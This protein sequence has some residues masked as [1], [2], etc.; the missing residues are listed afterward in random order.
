[1]DV[2]QELIKQIETD[3]A[4]KGHRTVA[5]VG[6]RL[7]GKTRKGKDTWLHAV[8]A[9][10][11]DG[12]IDT[13]EQQ[14]GLAIPESLRRLYRITNGLNLFSDE[15]SIDGLRRSFARTADNA[16]QPYSLVEP[17]TL[18]RPSGATKDELFI[19]GYSYDGSRIKLN[20]KTGKVAACQA[21]AAK[22]VFAQ[23]PDLPTFLRKEYERLAKL[24]DDELDLIDPDASTLPGS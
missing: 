15:L 18:E 9:P 13:L 14:V 6:A 4:P 16:W 19:G 10:L 3:Y 2:F 8:F 24:F 1:M 22:E 12:D 11:K 7:F 5:A 21:E 23:W 17:N 20:L